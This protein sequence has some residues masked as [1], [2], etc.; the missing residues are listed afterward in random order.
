MF[1]IYIW[2]FYFLDALNEWMYCNVTMRVEWQ[3]SCN[4]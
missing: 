4:G 2:L 3:E 1:R